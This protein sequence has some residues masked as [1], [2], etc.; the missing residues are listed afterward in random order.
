MQSFVCNDDLRTAIA[1]RLAEFPVP[2]FCLERSACGCCGCGGYRCRTRADILGIADQRSWS[3]QAALLLTR[4]AATLRN[5]PGQWA[6]P[7]GRGEL[8]KP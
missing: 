7:G 4:R 1:Q 6:F 5:H 8:A 2:R 3:D